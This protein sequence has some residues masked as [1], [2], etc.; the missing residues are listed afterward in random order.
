MIKK[1]KIIILFKNIQFIDW[2]VRAQSAWAYACGSASNR[3]GWARIGLARIGLHARVCPQTARNRP[4]QARIG[5]SRP[6][7]AWSEWDS[8]HTH[9]RDWLGPHGISSPQDNN[10]FF[11]MEKYGIFKPFQVELQILQIIYQQ[12]AYEELFQIM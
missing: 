10:P 11:Q 8:A 12:K 5:P 9:G 6:G 4:G 2:P 1:F 7:L 3:P